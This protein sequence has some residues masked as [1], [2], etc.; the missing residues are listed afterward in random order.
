M[1]KLRKRA[2]SQTYDKNCQGAIAVER[3][4]KASSSW[5][6]IAASSHAIHRVNAQASRRL[7]QQQNLYHI[8]DFPKVNT[9]RV[10]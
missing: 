3:D 4:L 10:V 2:W 1:T 6:M 5:Q 7:I 9:V 8:I